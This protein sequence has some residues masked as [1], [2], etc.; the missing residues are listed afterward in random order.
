MSE[1]IAVLVGSLRKGSYSKQIAKNLA[2]LFPSQYEPEFIEIGNLPLY[3]E[4]I[5]TPESVPA[6]Y[7][8]FRNKIKNVK[9]VLFVTPEYNRSVPAALKNALDVGSRPYGQSAWDMK[10]AAIVSVSPGAI[11][12]FGANHHLRQSLVFLNMPVLQQPE[13]YIG[14]V[15]NILDE[16]GN[17]AEGTVGFLQS[18]VDAYVDLLNRY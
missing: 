11:S 2:K 7:T 1:K 17:V 6:E 18:I 3:N 12:G 9:G 4:D 16:N 8:E 14:N 15:T 5:D 10:P 13:A